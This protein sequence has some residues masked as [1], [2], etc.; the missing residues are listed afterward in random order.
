MS[1]ARERIQL[2]VIA[3]APV[4][5]RVKTRLC[6]PATYAQAA[7]V[8]AASIAD[9]LAAGHGFARRTVVLDGQMAVPPGWRVVRQHGA[10]LGD[11]LANAFA[12]TARR[13]VG[14]LLIGMDTPQVSPG[15]LHSLATALDHAADRSGAGVD[16]V[17]GP[18]SDG[19][20]WSLALR[21]P[22]I[23]AVLRDVPMSTAE[24]GARTLD[25]LRAAG[26]RVALGPELRDVDTAEDAWAVAADCATSSS[27]DQSRRS[28]F[29]AAVRACL[30]APVA[31]GAPWLPATEVAG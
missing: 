28:E 18:A 30:P 5:G 23:A 11:R 31:L 15:M 9:T 22:L 17:L 14:S 16:A 6:P 21:D 26:L 8:A 1:A 24:T 13:G 3:K 4:P 12:D 2:L 29:D 25:A 19:G 20:W 10:G 7:V 27:V